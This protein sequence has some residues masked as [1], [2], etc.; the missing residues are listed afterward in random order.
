MQKAQSGPILKEILFFIVVLHSSSWA[1]SAV[2]GLNRCAHELGHITVGKDYIGEVYVEESIVFTSVR[3]TLG[4]SALKL[5]LVMNDGGLYTFAL[6]SDSYR[7]IQFRIPNSDPRKEPKTYYMKYLYSST[8]QDQYSEFGVDSPVDSMSWSKYHPL[9][10]VKV[11]DPQL[12]S[13]WLQSLKQ[14]VEAISASM[15][16]GHL[17]Q[18]DLMRGN[19]SLCKDIYPLK[20]QLTQSLNHRLEN[21]NP[22]GKPLHENIQSFKRLP[23]SL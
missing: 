8:M 1:D 11:L 23:A 19:L 12:K 16:L 9:K 15:A 20:Q 5:L 3:W 4:G 10:L 18:E 7:R 2:L 21:L 13:M 17:D 6:P 22:A 14:K